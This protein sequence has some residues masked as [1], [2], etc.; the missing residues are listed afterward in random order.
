VL[1][2]M[3]SS[4]RVIDLTKFRRSTPLRRARHPLIGSTLPSLLHASFR[5]KAMRLSPLPPATKKVPT[6]CEPCFLAAPLAL[7][8]RATLT[9]LSRDHLFTRDTHEPHH[10]RFDLVKAPASK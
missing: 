10:L 9:N 6:V 8:T 4:R 7:V 3:Q 1:A 2:G 5:C